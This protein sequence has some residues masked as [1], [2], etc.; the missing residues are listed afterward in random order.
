MAFNEGGATTNIGCA[1]E[2][3]APPLTG[4][5]ILLMEYV[6]RTLC[7][8]SAVGVLEASVSGVS[9]SSVALDPAVMDA[10]AHCVRD[11]T[12]S[13]ASLRMGDERM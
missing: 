9:V 6:E 13:P 7:L 5:P 11:S 10:R 12:S 1:S 4:R 8:L 3:M 2:I